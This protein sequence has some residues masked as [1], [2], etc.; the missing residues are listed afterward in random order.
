MLSLRS[1]PA[2]AR[3]TSVS[4]SCIV[5]AVFLPA[6]AAATITFPF[7]GPPYAV[8]V[9]ANDPLVIGSDTQI[10]NLG[11]TLPYADSLT[12]SHGDAS[13]TVDFTLNQGSFD[14][15]VV[16]QSAGNP[17]GGDGSR[18]FVAGLRFTVDTETT[19]SIDG[20]F[21]S[22]DTVGNGSASIFVWLQDSGTL[23]MTDQ[24]EIIV[25]GEGFGLEV[26]GSPGGDNVNS[27]V[28]SQN[29]TLLPGIDYF[30]NFSLGNGMAQTLESGFGSSGSLSISFVPVPEPG[31]LSMLAA[32][33]G[34][35]AFLHS[36][37]QVRR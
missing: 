10:I 19:Y 12:A 23:F 9:G 25:N 2:T 37:R 34:L 32:G 18:S 14:F 24:Q 27:I 3:I 36:R 28:G 4:A 13:A 6:I 30:L 29:G 33:C 20:S 22:G 26:G 7:A 11:T 8:S 15:D 31:Q 5:A 17:L 1:R 21:A 35:L 16:F